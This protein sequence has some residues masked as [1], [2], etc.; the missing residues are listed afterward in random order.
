MDAWRTLQAE[1]MDHFLAGR[2]TGVQQKL[3][4][5]SGNVRAELRAACPRLWN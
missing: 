1:M 5:K 3:L 2:L 4:V